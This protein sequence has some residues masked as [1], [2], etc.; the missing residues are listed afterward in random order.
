MAKYEDLPIEVRHMVVLQMRR[1][2]F[3]ERILKFDQVFTRPMIS[4]YCLD[5][6]QVMIVDVLWPSGS[7]CQM[8]ISDGH[9]YCRYRHGD[10][11]ETSRWYNNLD[12]NRLYLRYG[13]RNIVT[14]LYLT[15][16][17]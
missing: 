2:H 17:R 16:I 11:K 7:F 15:A 5:R 8:S 6:I 10:E 9:M 12:L 3:Q 1:M 4:V 14:D 13:R